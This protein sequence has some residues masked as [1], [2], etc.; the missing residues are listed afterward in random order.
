MTLHLSSTVLYGIELILIIVDE[1]SVDSKETA[2]STKNMI[3]HHNTSRL[4]ACMVHSVFLI[5]L[6][7][8]H[9]Y[10]YICV[11]VHQL[12]YCMSL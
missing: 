11:Y 3:Q 1:T 12:M 6:Y 8:L 10:T 5:I 2:K 9:Y 4:A 7:E